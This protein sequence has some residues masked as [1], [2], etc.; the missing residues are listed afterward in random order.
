VSVPLGVC[1]AMNSVVA[2]DGTI[3]R[4]N[5]S[6]T[7]VKRAGVPFKKTPVVPS[8]RIDPLRGGSVQAQCPDSP[9]FRLPDRI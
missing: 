2:P 3:A 1:T 4:M 9:D 6:D 8:A 5:V 7:T